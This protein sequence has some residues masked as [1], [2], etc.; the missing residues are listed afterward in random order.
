MFY[1]LPPVSLLRYDLGLRIAAI[2]KLRISRWA[3][4]AVYIKFL[5]SP[6]GLLKKFLLFSLY[7]L[8]LHSINKP[9]SMFFLLVIGVGEKGGWLERYLS[10]SM[11][12]CKISCRNFLT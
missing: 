3:F 6:L 8:F 4:G 11:I 10:Y 12:H 7:F 5:C 9:Y 2:V 1:S